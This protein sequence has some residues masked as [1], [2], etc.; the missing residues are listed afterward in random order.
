MNKIPLLIGIVCFI[1]YRILLYFTGDIWLSISI[2]LLPIGLLIFNFLVRK[3]LSF[4][5]W[6]LSP[7]NFLLERVSHSFESD[8]DEDLIVDKLIEVAENSEFK[9]LD[10]DKSKRQILL[11]KPTNFWTWGENI[12]IQI[13]KSPDGSIVEFTS[14]T[15]YGM[16]SWKRNDKNFQSFIELFESSLI[17]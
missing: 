6:F 17:I 3:Q 15:L 11:G 13:I 4:S 9:L 8:L 14:V 1:I 12:Y 16:N 7:A 2:F 5:G 10:T